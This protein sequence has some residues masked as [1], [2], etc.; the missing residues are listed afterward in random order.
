MSTQKIVPHL[1]FNQEAKEAAQFYTSI[2]PD[3]K[4]TSNATVR[5]TPSGDSDIVTF[6]LA[7]Y[8]FMAINGGPHFQ[9]NPAISFFV[10]F[11]PS[12][13]EA[14]S[15]K[16]DALW[17]K[18]SQGGAAL[19]PLQEYP[20]SKRYGWVQD[21][22]G[23]TWQLMLT[24]P[25]GKERPFI[26]PSMMF[27]QDVCGK[28][29]EATDYYLSVFPDSSRGEM[30]RYP[31]GMEPDKEGTLMYTDF[32]LTNQ[33]FV[34]MDSAWEHEFTFNEAISLIIRCENQEE[35]DYYWEKLSTD[36]N[37]EQCGWCKDQYGVSWQ[38]WPEIIG[39]MMATG[40][41]EQIDR[42]TKAFLQMKK[43]D[44]EAL[45]KAFQG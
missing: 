12:R 27:V 31:A 13:D 41:R 3:S 2:F 40:T 35:I 44:I 9:F 25:D 36:P 7:G 24:N 4:I 15:E 39:D 21:K 11:D 17:E 10:H 1:W 28:A 18:L 8:S 43:Y 33:R 5:D 14:A 29:E 22:Y 19:M 34:A 38:V 37:A 23:L 32:L 16:L 26:V 45:K 20:F 6:D 42:L 30:T